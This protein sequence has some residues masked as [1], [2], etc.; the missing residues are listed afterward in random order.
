MRVTLNL[1]G[2]GGAR[3]SQGDAIAEAYEASIRCYASQT[4]EALWE[5]RERGNIGEEITLCKEERANA[6]ALTDAD[7]EACKE[8]ES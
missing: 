5:D 3:G 6:A 4:C 1:A 2:R 7:S 8:I